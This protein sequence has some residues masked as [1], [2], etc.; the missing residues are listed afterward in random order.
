M[1]LVYSLLCAAIFFFWS[2]FPCP[3]LSPMC[4]P[5]RVCSFIRRGHI[6][7]ARPMQTRRPANDGTWDQTSEKMSQSMLASNS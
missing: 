1:G 3:L 7:R 4:I 2:S 5:C 6:Q